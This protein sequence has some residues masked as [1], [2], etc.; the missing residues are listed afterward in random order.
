M[1]ER[2]TVNPSGAFYVVYDNERKDSIYIPCPHSVATKKCNR[3]NLIDRIYWLDLQNMNGREDFQEAFKKG[4]EATVEHF[5][6]EDKKL[7]ERYNK[8]QEALKNS[9]SLMKQLNDMD[10]VKGGKVFL[11]TQ[12]ELNE[13]ALNNK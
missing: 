12:I 5:E 4:I 1:E 8:S 11:T 13:Q 10:F 7:L 2:Y 6:D 3:M 9:Q